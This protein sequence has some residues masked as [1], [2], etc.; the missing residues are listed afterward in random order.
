M[1]LIFSDFGSFFFFNPFVCFRAYSFALSTPSHVPAR[2]LLRANVSTCVRLLM[3]VCVSHSLCVMC[4]CLRC[5]SKSV[6]EMR[7]ESEVPASC[8][9]PHPHPLSTVHTTTTVFPCLC[10]HFSLCHS[11]FDEG[12]IAKLYEKCIPV[13]GKVM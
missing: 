5:R 2:L 6:R 10:V 3:C 1:F 12:P 7:F 9:P 8:A 4:V 13:A 11:H